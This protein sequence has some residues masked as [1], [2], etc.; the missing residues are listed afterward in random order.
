[1]A[2]LSTK[3]SAPASIAALR[4]LCSSWTL[5]TITLR[6][7]QRCPLASTSARLRMQVIRKTEGCDLVI[8]RGVQMGNYEVPRRQ[9]PDFAAARPGRDREFGGNLLRRVPLGQELQDLPLARRNGSDRVAGLRRPL[10]HGLKNLRRKLR[11][12][13]GLALELRTCERRRST[14]AR[15]RR[16]PLKSVPA[17]ANCRVPLRT[18]R[19]SNSRRTCR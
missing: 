2:R 18:S 7:G 11:R 5:R 14:P 3:A 17:T 19:K 1:M 10:L 9:N 8:L 13:V 15:R 4:T 16:W 6:S 12:E